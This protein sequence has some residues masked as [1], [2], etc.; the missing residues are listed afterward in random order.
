MHR[1]ISMSGE[2]LIADTMALYE[3]DNEQEKIR[4]PGPIKNDITINVNRNDV[5][6]LYK[7]LL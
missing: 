1:L 2:F 6:L 5:F 3:R 4:I 7:I